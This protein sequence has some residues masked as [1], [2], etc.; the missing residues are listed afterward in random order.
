MGEV[1]I[2]QKL[3]HHNI[4]R[5]YETYDTE[6]GRNNYLYLVMEFCDGGEIFDSFEEL[7]KKGEAY[8]E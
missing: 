6:S 4:V 3:D 1:E 5:Y 8:T 7:V 2:L